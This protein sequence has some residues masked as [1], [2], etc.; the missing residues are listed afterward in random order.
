V[1]SSAC[2]RHPAEVLGRCALRRV[3]SRSK[4][5]CT[6]AAVLQAVL[7]VFCVPGV[8]YYYYIRDTHMKYKV[9]LLILLSLGH[10]LAR[11]PSVQDCQLLF[12]CI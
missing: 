10:R 5:G 1:L 6:Y 2:K 8:D 4:R 11:V 12:M 7:P 3:L 9:L